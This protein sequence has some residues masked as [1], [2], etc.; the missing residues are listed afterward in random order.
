MTTFQ[1]GFSTKSAGHYLRR[2]L[3]L[4]LAVLPPAAAIVVS[5]FVFSTG[6]TGFQIEKTQHYLFIPRD[7]TGPTPVRAGD[8]ITHI[9]GMD[10]YRV[11]GYVLTRPEVE[12]PKQRLT[13]QRNGRIVFLEVQYDPLHPARFFLATGPYLLFVLLSMVMCVAIVG[14]TPSGQPAGLFVL[15]LSSFSLLFVSQFPIQFGIVDPAILSATT[16]TTTLANWIGF[17]AWLHFALRFPPERQ[18]WTGKPWRIGAVV[19]LAPPMVAIGLSLWLSGGEP[20][21]FGWLQRLRRWAVPLIVA[22]LGIKLWSDYRAVD[23]VQT[24][25]QI[26]LIIAGISIGISTY[27][28]LYL[29]P[30]IIINR[31]LVP[32]YVVALTCAL[33]PLALF[34]AIVRYRLLDVDQIISWTV[35]HFI[36]LGALLAACSLVLYALKQLL[37]EQSF[38]TESF[39]IVFILIVAL[40][41]A[42]IRTRLEHAIDVLFFKQTLDFRQVLHLFSSD[43][44]AAI[45]MSDLIHTVVHKL[46]AAFS[47]DKA[48]L[49]IAADGRRR[50]YPR[51]EQDLETLRS[52]DAVPRYIQSNDSPFLLCAQGYPDP[53]MADE[54]TRLHQNG[55]HLALRLRS[56]TAFMGMML[57][58]A[59][60]NG[61][62]YSG[63]DIQALSTLANQVATAVENALNYES[64]ERSQAELKRMFTKV[65]HAEKLAAIGEM[66]AVLAHELKNPLGVIRSSAQYIAAGTESEAGHGELLEFIVDEVDRLTTVV[67]HMLDMARYAPPEFNPVRLDQ[68]LPSIVQR[69]LQ[70]ADHNAAVSIRCRCDQSETIWADRQQLVQVA[71]N[72]IRNSEEAMPD[73]GRLEIA[74]ASDDATDSVILR[75]TDTGIGVTPDQV[76]NLWKKFYTTKKDGIGLGLSVCKQIVQG[77]GG[78]IGIEA[79]ETNGLT[80]SIRL[81]RRPEKTGSAALLDGQNGLGAA[82]PAIS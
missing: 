64:L 57:L 5:I 10:N 58:G 12:A 62:F 69:W 36:L 61:A 17:S 22:V 14:W 53:G 38:L 9:G 1:S 79:G 31:P 21:F 34:L 70:S 3:L 13:I 56:R 54:M 27:L 55:Y 81:P 65:I 50:I 29:I 68:L 77:H 26:R 39:F 20:E 25:N 66:A 52:I 63:R 75:F 4:V 32:F 82:F 19:Y 37:G 15:T 48:A 28:F 45:K 30:N 2:W 44:G 78:A 76:D 23:D 43:I 24:R 35:S 74:L 6:T 7:G 47:L 73:G 49:L 41:F 8:R 18:V 16:L 40:F 59:K 60:R 72:L 33:I 67:N 42:P 11:L 46:P 71:V 80:V 51:E